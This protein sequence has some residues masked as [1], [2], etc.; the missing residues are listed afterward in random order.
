MKSTGN[1]ATIYQIKGHL[2][3]AEEMYIQRLGM[4]KRV[5]GDEHPDTL[6]SMNYLGCMYLEQQ[7]LGKAEGV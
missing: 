5:W 1:L 4:R 6:T 2:E 7:R 3:Q